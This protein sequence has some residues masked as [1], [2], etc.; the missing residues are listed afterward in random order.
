MKRHGLAEPV[1][2]AIWPKE[3]DRFT[4]RPWSP[5]INDLRDDQLCPPICEEY[6]DAYWWVLKSS[7]EDQSQSAAGRFPETDAEQPEADAEDEQAPDGYED[8]YIS[9]CI[10]TAPWHQR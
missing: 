8:E 4:R 3:P 2:D 5:S 10:A 7:A 9:D 6:L 1:P